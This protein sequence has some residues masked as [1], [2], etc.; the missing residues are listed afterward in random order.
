MLSVGH[1]FRNGML[2]RIDVRL[3]AGFSEITMN[4]SIS[5][6]FENLVLKP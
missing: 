4:G 5:Y 1:F 2:A 3:L 6:F